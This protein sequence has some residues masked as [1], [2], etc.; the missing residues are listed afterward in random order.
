MLGAVVLE[1]GH[2]W[3]HYLDAHHHGGVH[4][5]THAHAT[6]DHHGHDHIKELFVL[7][8]PPVHLHHH[9]PQVVAT[10]GKYFTKPRLLFCLKQTL[11][12]FSLPFYQA[13]TVSITL[14]PAS[15]PPQA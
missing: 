5:H 3:L 1:M 6:E 10:T 4:H 15:P 11:Y 8:A 12:M 9:L 2:H 13:S 14:V 7:V